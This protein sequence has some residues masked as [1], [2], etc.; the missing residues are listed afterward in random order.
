M[1]ARLQG[2]SQA[3]TKQRFH[4]H[5]GLGKKPVVK[6]HLKEATTPITHFALSVFSGLLGSSPLLPFP[7]LHPPRSGMPKSVPQASAKSMASDVGLRSRNRSS[8]TTQK[9]SKAYKKHHQ[10]TKHPSIPSHQ[11]QAGAPHLSPC[12]CSRSWLHPSPPAPRKPSSLQAPKK[13]SSLPGRANRNP[14]ASQ[15]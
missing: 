2:F 12:S 15:T 7:A 10:P 5:C 8:H 11:T 13:S 6:C 3:P 9:D 14:R 4:S 1:R